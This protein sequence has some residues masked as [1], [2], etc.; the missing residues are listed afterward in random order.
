MTDPVVGIISIILGLIGDTLDELF[1]L[2]GLPKWL[3]LPT[4]IAAVTLTFLLALVLDILFIIW[5]ERKVI[6]RIHHRRSITE[7]GPVGFLQNVADLIKLLVKE[8]VY[9]A[10]ADKFMHYASPILIASIAIIP[11]VLIPY[12]PQTFFMRM[13]TSVVLFFAIATLVPGIVLLA[14]W[15]GNSKYSTIGAFRAGLQLIS[16]EIPL[17]LSIL[18]VI[19]MARSLDFYRIIEAQ[20]NVWFAILQPLGAFT[21]FVVSLM[22]LERS[23]FDIPEAE[24]EILVGW[25]TEYSGLKFGLFYA[26]EY[27][28][29]FIASAA[30]TALF[31]G[32]WHGLFFDSVIYFLLKM[33]IVMLVMIWV[34]VT[35]FRPRPDQLVRISYTKLIPLA[36]LNLLWVVLINPF[37][38]PLLY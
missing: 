33:H 27:F 32:G 15:A 21:F 6:G 35:F 26:A 13:S 3:Y 28:K 25:R 9:P 1:E 12:G 8:D 34:R 5:M 10:N 4:F 7:T 38:L 30:F 36:I 2:L 14:G 17:S 20:S 19:L 37:V 29:F 11:A 23:P 16:Y 22:E 31:L 18:G 24:G